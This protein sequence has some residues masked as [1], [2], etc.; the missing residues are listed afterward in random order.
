MRA[1]S[2]T[3]IFVV[4]AA[5]FFAAR[6]VSAQIIR[7][8]LLEQISEKPVGGASL[9][10]LSE[11][12]AEVSSAQSSGSSEFTLRASAP[13]MYRISVAKKGYRS[14]ETPTLQLAAGDVISVTIHIMPDKVELSPAIV[15][16]NS[17]RPPGRLA[18]FY[19]RM[20]KYHFGTFI[21]RDQIDKRR[22]FEVSDLLRSIPGLSVRPAVC[23]FGYNVR[24]VEGCRPTVYLDGVS[25]PLMR[26]ETIDDIANP[27]NLEGVE[28]YPHAPEVPA[29]L[30][31]GFGR[32][33]VIALWTRA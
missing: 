7:G 26:S 5:L 2:R 30:Y 23:G 15:T 28:V 3:P 16:S 19:D 11:Q 20:Q 31:R 24:T 14:T 12:N 22:P 17:R 21:T 10:L 27:M 25:F 33:G 32:C 8:K 13:G 29:E 6:P 9:T 4:F 1:T 18:G